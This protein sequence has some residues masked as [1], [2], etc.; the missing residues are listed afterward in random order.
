M[1][2]NDDYFHYGE[3]Q[4]KQKEDNVKNV[5]L[6]THPL[7]QR[8]LTILRSVRTNYEEFR[9]VLHRMSLGIAYE[10]F[11]LVA[12]KSIEVETPLA[13]AKGTALKE[14]IVLVPILR[15]G[16]GL[17][18]GFLE[19]VPDARVGHIGVYR[20]EETLQPVEYYCKIPKSLSKAFVVLLDPMLATGGSLVHAVKLLKKQ[21]AKQILCV[22]VIAAPEG[23]K[24][25]SKHYP[26]LPLITCAIDKKLNQ[27]G[28]IVPGLGDAGDRYF[29][30][31]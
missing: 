28:Y 9:N 4:G 22:S 7:V 26:R 19:L 18:S 24:Y 21:E 5:H 30:T 8:D 2:S 1:K 29:G 13:S 31:E 6:I 11:R 14:D 27:N 10:A 16:L 12:T 15:A 17:L 23:I 25:V 20:N 3:N